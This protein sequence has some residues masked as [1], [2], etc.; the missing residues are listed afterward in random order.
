MIII[1]VRR[2][3]R[4]YRWLNIVLSYLPCVHIAID[5]DDEFQ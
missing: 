3:R 4:I 2:W 1:P 5:C